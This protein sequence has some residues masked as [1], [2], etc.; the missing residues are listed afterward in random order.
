M[1]LVNV[2][3]V[4]VFITFPLKNTYAQGDFAILKKNVNVRAEGL[5]QKLNKTKDT[6]ILKSD[7]IIQKV[8][9]VNMNYEREVDIDVRDTSI[10]IPLTNL[11]KGKHVFVAVQSPLRLVFT[12]KIIGDK[13]TLVA[14]DSKLALKT[15]N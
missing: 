11:S 2:I 6:L 4:F 5:S 15:N 14:L 12:V 3:I 1:K 8:Y 13:D 7:R 10:K 9:A